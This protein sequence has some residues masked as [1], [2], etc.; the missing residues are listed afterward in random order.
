MTSRP[1]KIAVIGLDCALTHLIEKHISE[2]HL[3]TFKK[4]FDEGVVAD[5]S[6]PNFPTVTPPNWATLSTGALDGTHGITDFH[7]HEVGTDLDNSSI[8]Q[9][10]SSERCQAEFIWDAADKA[11][12]KCVVLN[13]PGSWPP[14]MENGIMIGGTG[15]AIGEN[16][17]GLWG[18]DVQVDLC[19][20]QMITTGVYPVAIRGQLEEASDW[21][22]VPEMGED[23]LEMKA[24]LNFPSSIAKPA[25][26]TWHV[27]IR[28]MGDDGYDT[29]TLSPTKDMDDAFCTL[30][31][32]EWSPK[33]FTDIEMEDGS[34]RKV[35]FRCKLIELSDDAEDF[36][37]FIGNLCA[38][39]GWTSPPD[40]AEKIAAYS[41]EGTFGSSGGLRGYPV[42]WYGL[43]TYVEINEQYSQFLADAAVY[44]LGNYDWDIFYMHSHPTDW[45]YHAVMSDMDPNTCPDE[46]KRKAA[47]KAHLGIYETQDRMIAKI[48]EALGEETLVVLVSDHGATADGPMLD[49]FDILVP[50]GLCAKPEPVDIERLSGYMKKAVKSVGANMKPDPKKSK[51]IPQRE[52]YVYVNLKGRDP[53]GIVEPEDYNKV[54]QEIID[55]L[56]AYVEPGTGK[57]PIALALSKQDARILGLYG[58]GIGDVVYALYPWFGSQHGQ[59]LPTAEFGV[60]SLKALFTLTGPGVKKGHRLQRSVWS[61]DLVPTICYLL[62]LPVPEHAEGAVLYQAFEDP[63]FKAKEIRELKDRLAKFEK[64]L[65]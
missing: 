56:Y 36:R 20:D 22:N 6:M 64:Q 14:K 7:V 62:D 60:G 26:T 31:K 24:E 23:P 65:A 44:T 27:L 15:L 48:L 49:P 19:H 16:R 52:I 33:I 1:K 5:N 25:P 47:W 50:A 18:L 45:V 11:G 3:P 28:E 42:G 32:G 59:I 30:T 40:L 12:K 29:A 13:Y 4:L 10:F 58:D 38:T 41:K 46:E 17:D 39:S 54:Q 61:T 35:F 43:D 51:A 37:L 34:V 21:K 9:A 8:R 57:R 55:A 53:D 63:N 2:G